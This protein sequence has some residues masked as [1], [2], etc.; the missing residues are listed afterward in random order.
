MSCF[1]LQF[2]ELPLCSL[3]LLSLAWDGHDQQ[4]CSRASLVT[5]FQAHCPGFWRLKNV[6]S[7]L[8]FWM[9]T[10]SWTLL[11][12]FWFHLHAFSM[13]KSVEFWV[14]LEQ[15]RHQIEK[16]SN[17]YKSSIQSECL[18]KTGLWLCTGPQKHVECLY[19]YV[20]RWNNKV[21]GLRTSL[22]M[23]L[24]KITRLFIDKSLMELWER[25]ASG[26]NSSLFVLLCALNILTGCEMQWKFL[27]HDYIF[28]EK[29][30]STNK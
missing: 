15:V 10:E 16:V 12:W 30:N 14:K 17:Y 6:N 29:T 22:L 26:N 5:L 28:T 24:L 4:Q 9:K 23:H 3:W 20:R 25:A 8:R 21:L 18:W 1:L 19:V 27:R 13:D 11:D 2:P 7:C